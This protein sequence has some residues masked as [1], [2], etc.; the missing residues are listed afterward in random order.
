MK[1]PWI[2]LLLAVVPMPPELTLEQLDRAE[3]VFARK[4]CVA[5]HVLKGNP[6]AKGQLGPELSKLYKRKPPVDAASLSA[7]LVHPRAENPL[8]PMPELGV[9]EEE[10]RILVQYLLSPRPRRPRVKATPDPSR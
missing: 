9:T 8:D 1:R 2:M 3:A 7:Y 5:C 10:A 6:S 4:G